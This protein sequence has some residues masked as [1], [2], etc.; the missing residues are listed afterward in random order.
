MKNVFTS[1]KLPAIISSIVVLP[2]MLLELINRQGFRQSLHEAFPIP[3]LGILWLL[4]MIF[5]IVLMPTVRKVR[6][7]RKLMANPIMLLLSASVLIFIAWL[8]VGI[9]RDQMPCFLGVLNC[10]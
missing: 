6:A 5:C 10:D 4:P 2:F 7:G 8:W 3:L 9:I 1:L